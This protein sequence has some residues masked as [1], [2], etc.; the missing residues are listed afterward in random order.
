MRTTAYNNLKSK[1]QN[2][3]TTPLNEWNPAPKFK[4]RKLKHQLKISLTHILAS[5]N[6]VNI[7]HDKIL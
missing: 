6:T 5:N 7:I 1:L 4:E 3:P 2:F